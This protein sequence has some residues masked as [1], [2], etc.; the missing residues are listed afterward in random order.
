MNIN[1][2]KI[3]VTL[4]LAVGTLVITTVMYFVAGDVTPAGDA[5]TFAFWFDTAVT[6][7]GLGVLAGIMADSVRYLGAAILPKNLLSGA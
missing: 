5:K 1:L 4:W 7:S 2:N 6:T 3:A